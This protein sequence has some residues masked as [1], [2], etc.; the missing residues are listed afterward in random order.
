MCFEMQ[1]SSSPSD[2][3]MSGSPQRFQVI[4]TEPATTPQ[5]IQ[6]TSDDKDWDPAASSWCSALAAAVQKLIVQHVL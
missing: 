3:I 5:R 2:S 6:V 1:V 4:S